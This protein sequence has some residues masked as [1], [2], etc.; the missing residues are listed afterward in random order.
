MRQQQQLPS[1]YEV[2]QRGISRSSLTPGMLITALTIGGALVLLVSTFVAD[3]LRT[4]ELS[5]SASSLLLSP[6]GD[7]DHDTTSVTYSLLEEIRVTAQ[8][9]GE[10]GGLV[11]TLLV[12]RSQ[13]TGQHFIV[14]DG[15]NDF[16]QP[17]ADGRYRLQV[18]AK[19][20]IRAASQ[21]I[22]LQVDTQPPTLRLLN[23]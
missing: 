1:H 4:P 7:G 20:P 10:G 22:T 17:V 5:V 2:R 15:L 9:F 6:N 12:D 16:N 18:T 23:V 3:W 13:A 21:G 19:G 8:V 14:W 11:R